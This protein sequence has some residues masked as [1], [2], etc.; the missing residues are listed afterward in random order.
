M[1]EDFLHFLWKHKKFDVLNIKTA[2]AETIQLVDVGQHNQNSGP[3]FFNAKLK[4]ENQLWAGNV[5]IH[6]K[7]SN[8]YAHQHET[9]KAY[10][11][12]ILHVVWEHDAEVYRKDNSIIPTLLLQEFVPKNLI[13]NYRRLFSKQQRWINCEANFAEV[14][15]FTLINWK[16][17]LFIERLERKS[18][19]IERLLNDSNQHWEAVLFT[20]LFRNFGLKV[21]ADAF[22]SIAKSIDFSI[23]RKLQTQSEQLEALFC[24]QAGLLESNIEEAYYQNLKKA[25]QYLKQ[26]FQLETLGVVPIQFFRLRPPN[27]PTI[28][29]SQ[30]AQLYHKH[31]NLFS[32]VISI[33]TIEEFYDL[34]SVET[35]EYWQTHYSFT[36]ISKSS[37]KK[38]TKSFIDLLIINTIIPIKYCFSK[39][40][41]ND[42][43]E[44]IFSLAT[45]I[46]SEENSIIKKFNQLAPISQSALDSQALLQLKSHYCDANKCLQCAIGNS[47]ITK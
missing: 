30:L 31:Y 7:S 44:I 1:Q 20:M 42:E 18:Q 2:K 29:L 4:I 28:R 34:F 12:V 9:D 36:S 35:S 46:K 27:F 6:V 38:L 21:N 10:D 5:E 45:A 13:E 22:E 40:K 26:K 24:G 39:Y 17:R 15:N 16:E 37:T 11:N 47:I 33:S 14:D 43:N 32:Q 19:Q 23:V 8:W 25:Y 41:G 3:D